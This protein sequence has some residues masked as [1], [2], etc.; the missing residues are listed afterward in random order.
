[1]VVGL[2]LCCPGDEQHADLEAS[3]LH[4]TFRLGAG[5][6]TEGSYRVVVVLKRLQKVVR[7]CV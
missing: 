1:M 7:S 5:T 2:D 3:D 6:E 4:A